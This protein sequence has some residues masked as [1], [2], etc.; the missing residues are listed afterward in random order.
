[1]NKLKIIDTIAFVLLVTVWG[2]Y[3][4][5]EGQ[6]DLDINERFTLSFIIALEYTAIFLIYAIWRYY[7]IKGKKVESIGAIFNRL[8]SG[9]EDDD[10][11]KSNK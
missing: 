2:F 6:T 4:L 9:T 8:Y 1:M 3:I 10:A 11:D 7:S 5:Y